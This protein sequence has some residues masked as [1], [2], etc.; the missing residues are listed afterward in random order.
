MSSQLRVDNILPSAGTALGIGTASG[1]ITFNSN[2]SGDTIFNND[3]TINGVLTYEDV[4]NIDSVGVLT[5]R[6]DI[7]LGND[8]YL[9]DGASGYEKVEIDSNDL[10]VE[11]KHIHSQFG[12]W[13]RSSSVD[14]RRNGIDGD[15]NDLLLY[16]NSAERLR[17]TSGGSVG[18]NTTLTQSS[19]TVHIAG[20]YRSVTQNVADEGLIFQSF[21]TA[22]T[23]DVYP[24]ISWTGNP[25]ALGRARASINAIATNDYNGSD[26][27]F[28]TRNQAD[29]TELD[30]TDDERL[31]IT[32]D[33]RLLLGTTDAGGNNTANHLVV[34][35]NAGANDQAGMT[36]RGGTSGRSQIFFSDGNSGQDEYRGM[37]RYDHQD[38]SMQ[39]RTNAVEKLRIT[40]AGNLGIGGLTNPGAL[41]SIPAGESNTPRFAIESA[42]D[43]NDFTITQYEDGN[44]TYTML[45]QNVKLNS[46]GNNT[47]LDSAH[48]TAG[49]LLDARNHGSIV[50]LTGGANAVGENV[51]IDS[52]GRVTKPAQ[53]LA[54]I[55]TTQNNWSP[56]AGDVLPFN[57]SNTNRGNHYNTS[58]YTFTCPVAGDYMVILRLS[59]KG[60]RGDVE[61]AKNNSQY[62]LLELRETGRNNSNAAD[63]QAWCYDFIVPCAAN[64]TLKFKAPN[65]YTG[66]GGGNYLLD[67]YDHIYYDSVTYYLMG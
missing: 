61:L 23:G 55:G 51:K 12:V 20:D 1:S 46:G 39:F 43:D 17:I 50:F 7:Y 67:G 11:G 59:R 57:Y 29:G 14:N 34:S 19:K 4:T 64:D 58:N 22:S 28:L 16:A 41:L 18:F 15:N 31:R 63:W 33:G 38:N 35:N 40:S 25:G 6:S 26:I 42:V 5:A 66:T 3:V 8:I 30:V 52:A 62:A 47:I 9:T 45:G 10:R 27:V 13:T 21:T 36:I 24:G 65:V 56:S 54:I 2:I 48:R 49:I 32:S 44:G 60:F 53:P 37:L